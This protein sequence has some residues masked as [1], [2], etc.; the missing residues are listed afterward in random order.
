MLNAN[1]FAIG[2]VEVPTL[3]IRVNIVLSFD[4]TERY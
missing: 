1:D 3:G 4:E 2:A